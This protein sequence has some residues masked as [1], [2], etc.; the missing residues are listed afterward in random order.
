M[1]NGNTLT[2][3]NGLFTLTVADDGI[4]L[5]GPNF[6]AVLNIDGIVLSTVAG[7]SLNLAAG[8]SIDLNGQVVLI[9]ENSGSVRLGGADGQVLRNIDTFICNTDTGPRVVNVTTLQSRVFA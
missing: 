8:G 2:S 7:A 6:S 1:S 5:S 3:P 4:R 9:G